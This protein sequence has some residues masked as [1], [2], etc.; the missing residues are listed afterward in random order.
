[1]GGRLRGRKGGAG[2]A[3]KKVGRKGWGCEREVNSDCGHSV[4]YMYENVKN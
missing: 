2:K 3:E 4:L 1:V